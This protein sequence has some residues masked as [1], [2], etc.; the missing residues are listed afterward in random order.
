MTVPGFGF[1]FGFGFGLA[2]DEPGCADWGAGERGCFAAFAAGDDVVVRSAAGAD[3]RPSAAQP[4]MS[5][6][7]TTPT[8]RDL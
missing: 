4:V 3:E 5:T 7:N 1:G 6:T 2:A 8:A